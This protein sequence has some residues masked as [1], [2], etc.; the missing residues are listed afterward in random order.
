MV[1]SATVTVLR[2]AAPAE[3][4]I[5]VGK[6]FRIARTSRRREHRGR[7][8]EI[9]DF[10]SLLPCEVIVRFD[11]GKRGTVRVQDLE[12]LEEPSPS[13]NQVEETGWLHRSIVREP[14]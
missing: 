3:M 6:R 1:K 9:T 8:G 12:E 14:S 5:A 4:T 10:N 7:L 2:G 13:P 11:N